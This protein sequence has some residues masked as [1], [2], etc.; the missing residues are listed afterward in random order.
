MYTT[1]RVHSAYVPRRLLLDNE[2]N[3][4]LLNLTY[5]HWSLWRHRPRHS[6]G[7]RS[8]VIQLFE[9]RIPEMENGTTASSTRLLVSHS[10][11]HSH[12]VN[13]LRENYS[14]FRPYPCPA[15]SPEVPEASS[16]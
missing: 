10:C 14:V 13:R 15:A 7:P 8:K 16:T 12:R 9:E 11:S 4:L 1:S 3:K 6:H 5:M 2:I